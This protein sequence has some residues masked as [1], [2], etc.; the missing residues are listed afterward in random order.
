MK[1]LSKGITVIPAY[2]LY[3]V[4]MDWLLGIGTKDIWDGLVRWANR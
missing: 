3:V 1:K 4:I 2:L